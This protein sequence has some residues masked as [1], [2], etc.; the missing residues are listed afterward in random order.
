MKKLK[1][2]LST[3]ALFV[4]ALLTAQVT[5]T[6]ASYTFPPTQVGTVDS[7]A[8]DVVLSD[9]TYAMVRLIDNA[10]N[11]SQT[12]Y[13]PSPSVLNGTPLKLKFQPG[14]AGTFTAKV[15][16]WA[17]NA[18]YAEISL[19]VID[20][21]GTAIGSTPPPER[22]GDEWLPMDNANP[23]V[24]MCETF[25]SVTSNQPLTIS[26]WKNIAQENYRAWWGFH[27][28][29]TAST[30]KATAYVMGGSPEYFEMWLITPPLDFA[31]A[32]SKWFSF[33]EMADFMNSEGE[34]DNA[35]LQ[36]YY[37]ELDGNGNPDTTELLGFDFPAGSDNEELWTEYRF[38]ISDMN[39]PI[40]DVFY[41]G[42]KMSATASSVV[43]YIDDVTWGLYQP[44]AIAEPPAPAA[45][46]WTNGKNIFISSAT[47]GTATLCSVSGATLAKYNF[48]QGLSALPAEVAAGIYFLKIDCNDHCAV[49]KIVMGK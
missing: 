29:D 9:R 19:A 7:V 20:V 11:P 1:L 28:G 22:Q 4:T 16:I 3:I 14:V 12:F 5:V 18:S 27:H 30:A 24:S 43:Y 47:H 46:A 48:S 42:F 40:A 23:L 35:R 32:A 44:T 34:A 38:D 8:F 31:N 26:R 39:M 6:P 36:V 33:K 49:K 45:T 2:C 13:L 37:I 17:Y 25:D 10:Q 21:A 15:E 41:I